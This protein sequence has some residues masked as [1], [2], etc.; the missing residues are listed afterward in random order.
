[1]VGVAGE[2]Q[3]ELPQLALPPH[4]TPPP[5]VLF[6][7]RDTPPAAAFQLERI[8]SPNDTEQKLELL[9]T[10]RTENSRHRVVRGLRC[11]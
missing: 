2:W 6:R 1:M 8:L 9:F 10:G 3:L 4:T 5:P 7:L 11:S